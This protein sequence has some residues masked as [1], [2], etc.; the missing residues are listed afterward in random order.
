MKV[1]IVFTSF[2]RY[3]ANFI[4]KIFVDDAEATEK[5]FK[6]LKAEA[7]ILDYD[8]RSHWVETYEVSRESGEAV[9][10]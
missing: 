4:E 9:E 1:S 8:E 5:A 10:I 6:E 7:E 2:D 3:G